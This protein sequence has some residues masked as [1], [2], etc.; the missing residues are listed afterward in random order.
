M[1][2]WIASNPI[3]VVN[4]LPN[5]VQSVITN[6]KRNAINVLIAV[7]ILKIK[8]SAL[9][10]STNVIKIGLNADHVVTIFIRTVVN[11]YLAV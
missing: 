1:K 5:L 6:V 4:V 2:K 11:P 7:T 8:S 9:N 10:V 3:V